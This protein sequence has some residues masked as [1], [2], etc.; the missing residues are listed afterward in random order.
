MEAN[1]HHVAKALLCFIAISVLIGTICFVSS[2]DLHNR[3]LRELASKKVRKNSESR[4][5]EHYTRSL[6]REHALM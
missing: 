2:I 3:V 5:N 4:F 6:G 1:D